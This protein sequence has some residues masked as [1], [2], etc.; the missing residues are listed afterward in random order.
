MNQFPS[1]TRL[2]LNEFQAS[3]YSHHRSQS[4][5]SVTNW[6]LR[7]SGCSPYLES[8]LSYIDGAPP[9]TPTNRGH[10]ITSRPLKHDPKTPPRDFKKLRTDHG[11]N[12]IKQVSNMF[13]T[14]IYLMSTFIINPFYI[15]GQTHTNSSYSIH[16]S[17]GQF[18]IV[19]VR[20]SNYHYLTLATSVLL[21]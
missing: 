5:L 7:V 11:P 12:I 1:H 17:P 8:L 14:H 16:E 13:I 6:L 18:D 2:D 4:A 10:G 3:C 9:W 15:P 19:V 20:R 21:S